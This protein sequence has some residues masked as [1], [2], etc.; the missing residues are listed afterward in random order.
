MLSATTRPT[1]MILFHETGIFDKKKIYIVI[2]KTPTCLTFPDVNVFS[3]RGLTPTPLIVLAV[4]TATSWINIGGQ[5]ITGQN[6]KTVVITDF[7]DVFVVLRG[8]SERFS[9]CR[10]IHPW[11]AVFILIDLIFLSLR[12]SDVRSSMHR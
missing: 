2:S 3:G 12:R 6:Q 7:I 11:S 9:L 5:W 10:G 8:F 4:S 1:F